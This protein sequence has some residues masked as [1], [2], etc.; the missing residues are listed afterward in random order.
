MQDEKSFRNDK[1]RTDRKGQGVFREPWSSL[2][3]PFPTSHFSWKFSQIIAEKRFN[4]REKVPKR[5]RANVRKTVHAD[6]RRWTQKKICANQR[7]NKKIISRRKSQ[8]EYAEVR[9]ELMLIGRKN[10]RK[11]ARNKSAM[12][13]EKKFRKDF[14]LMY[15]K[16]FTQMFANARCRYPQII[17]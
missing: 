11:S 14:A 8:I 1:Y 5:F 13:G 15:A 16:H 4:Q 10:L 2:P 12:I 9:R 7:E 3:F 17:L 6:N